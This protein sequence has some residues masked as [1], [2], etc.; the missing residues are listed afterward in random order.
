MIILR[1]KRKIKVFE[2]NYVTV[3]NK[4][5]LLIGNKETWIKLPL[6]K[7]QIRKVK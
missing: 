2:V 6:L 4:V 3:H 1:F 7:R 5:L